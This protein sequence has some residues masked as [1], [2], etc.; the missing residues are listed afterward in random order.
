MQSLSAKHDIQEGEQGSEYNDIKCTKFSLEMT[1]LTG[2]DTNIS[3][4]ARI[5]VL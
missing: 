4:G 5:K 1:P 3:E 2:A